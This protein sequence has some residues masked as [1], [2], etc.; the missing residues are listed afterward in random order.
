MGKTVD[1]QDLMKE[2]ERNYETENIPPTDIAGVRF[3]LGDLDLGFQW[4][5][6]AYA[7]HDVTLNWL[8]VRRD[9]DGVRDEPRYRAMLDKIGLGP[10]LPT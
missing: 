6:I 3:L 7:V 5:E 1:A 2:V 9:F 4:L 8:A 10:L